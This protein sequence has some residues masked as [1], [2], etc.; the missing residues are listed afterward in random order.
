MD[1]EEET[2]DR[3]EAVWKLRFSRNMRGQG[4]VNVESKT[5][6][7]EEVEGKGEGEN[8]EESWKRERRQP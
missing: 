2:Q 6:H 1:T 5:Q 7:S 8:I 3:E 4:L